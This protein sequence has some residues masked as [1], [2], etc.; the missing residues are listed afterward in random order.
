M[1]YLLYANNF[2]PNNAELNVMIGDCYLRSTDDKEQAI[3]YLEKATTL[4]SPLKSRAYELLGEAYHLTYDFDKAIQQLTLCKKFL[5]T[6]AKTYRDD[7]KRV[8]KRIAECETGK[9]LFKNPVQVFIDN[10]GNVVNT[11]YAEYGP[12]ITADG[13]TLYFTSLRPNEKGNSFE[14]EASFNEENY[15][16]DIYVTYLKNRKW[17]LPKALGSPINTPTNDAIAGISP[18]GDIMF[19]FL[20]ENG[21]DLGYTTLNGN[22]WMPP[23]SL[24]NA[25]NSPAHEASASLSPDGRTLYF[26][27]NRD[28]EI[29]G[30]HQI[31]YSNRDVDGAWTPAKPIGA[32]ITSGYDERTVFM[33]ANGKTLYFSSNGHNTMGGYDIFRSDFEK[34]RWTT[35]VNMGYPINTPEDDLFFMLSASER[36]AY[37]SSFR[38][39]GVGLHDLY[40]IVFIENKPVINVSEDNQIAYMQKPLAEVSVEKKVIPPPTTVAVAAPASVVVTLF[41]GVVT[42]AKTHKPLFAS[43]EIT[44]NDLSKVVASF[45]TNSQTGSYMVVLPSGKNYGLAVKAEN[46]LFHSENIDVREHAE[47]QE[48]YKEVELNEIVVGAKIVLNNIFFGFGNAELSATSIMELKLMVTLLNDQP[49]LRIEISGHTD[50]TGAAEFNK[51]LS[52]S[53]AKAVVDYLVE[54]GI[55]ADRL[56]F[57]GYGFDQPIEPNTTAKGRAANRRTEFKVL[58]N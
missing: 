52:E 28:N 46:Y 33:H 2:N 45:T 19:V 49:S 13:S 36:Y 1:P 8:N 38:K 40:R 25:I 32:P 39:G 44:D 21:G 50:N 31:Y 55:A 56:T 17:S 34:G 29:T 48:I 54:A 26:V 3:K 51:M 10:L 11:V 41:K 43:I 18:A 22:T 7:L 9:K 35:P 14:T 12:I 24:G 30:N 57:V 47:Y 42:D 4:P 53:R 16:E 6:K 15:T 23:K 37:F 27:S 58:E 20:S 5:D